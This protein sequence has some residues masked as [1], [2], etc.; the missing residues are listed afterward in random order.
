MFVGDCQDSR[1]ETTAV[2]AK[3]LYV[4][5]KSCYTHKGEKL[6]NWDLFGPFVISLLF[7]LVVYLPIAGDHNG[8]Q[9]VAFSLFFLFI[10]LLAFIAALNASLVGTYLGCLPTVS[11]VIYG[12]FPICLA[13]IP[14]KFLPFFARVI[15]VSAATIYALLV[16][17]KTLEAHVVKDR[18]VMAY[19]PIVFM[20][21]TAGVLIVFNS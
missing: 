21:I 6:L 5:G 7:P 8:T 18:W 16:S 1:E 10:W 19:Q 14:S 11:I 4:I 9:S 15:V 20:Y 13:S 2:G 12:I 17:K 3:L